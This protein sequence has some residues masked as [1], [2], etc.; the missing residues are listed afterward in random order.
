[1]VTATL[2]SLLEERRQRLAGRDRERDLLLELV[3]GDLPLVTVVHGVA[4]VGKSALLRAFAADARAEGAAVVAL[5]GRAV[6]PTEPGFVEALCCAAGC[7]GEE[8][9]DSAVEALGTL[10]PRVILAIDGYEAF[11]YLDHWLAT[12]LVPSLP[13]NVRVLLAARDRPSYA[14]VQGYGDVLRTVRLG[15]L[16]PADAEALLRR[17]GVDPSLNALAHG[18]PLTLQLAATALRDRPALALDRDA[19]VGAVVDQVAAEYLSGLDEPTRVALAAASITRRTTVSLLEATL[20]DTP[21]LEAFERLVQLPFVELCLDGLVVHDTMRAAAAACLRATDPA[22]HQRLRAAAHACLSRELRDA[23]GGDLWRY[24]AD[25]LYLVDNPIIRQFFFPHTVLDCSVEPAR[26]CDWPAIEALV[27]R[28]AHAELEHVAAWWRAAPE[29]FAVARDA[30]GRVVGYRCLAEHARVTADVARADPVA[31]RWR[32]HVRDDPVPQ[33]ATVL[34]LR[35]LATREARAV[36]SHA[37][38]A[39]LIDVKR[40]YMSHRPALRRTYATAPLLAAAESHCALVL[41]YGALPGEPDGMPYGERIVYN[42]YGPGS[43]DGW[44]A[45]L[46]ARELGVAPQTPVDPVLRR[47]R[48]DGAPVDLTQLEFD[49]LRYLQQRQGEAVAREAL[50][51]DVWGYEWTGGSN[52]VEV[53]ISGLRKKLGPRAAALKTVRGVGYRL[54]ALM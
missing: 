24:T 17:A 32:A 45:D 43:I 21:A 23:S 8:T 53:A 31:A 14:W 6:E 4:G 29:A 7:P 27:E 2:G 11:A 47:L 9:I 3:R 10:A 5:D 40:T 54:D 39:L 51:R 13:A 41:G 49:V 46:A 15:G 37:Q 25:L 16:A 34:F 44:L 48:L 50:L 19:M 42:D 38:A 22:K 36:P 30:D 12:T 1:M 18:H 33:G 35:F 28:D 52:V 20:P 26:P